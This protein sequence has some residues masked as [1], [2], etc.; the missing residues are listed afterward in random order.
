[1]KFTL[2]N[3]MIIEG[4]PDQVLDAA[5]K[6]G[7]RVPVAGKGTEDWYYSETNGTYIP[8]SGMALPH[9][10]NALLKLYRDWVADLSSEKDFAKLLKLIH[11]GPTEPVMIG[12][13]KELAKQVTKL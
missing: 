11:D 5:T 6:L 13:I 12:L 7:Y 2:P 1:L 10:K 3:G 8:I 4:T 9:I